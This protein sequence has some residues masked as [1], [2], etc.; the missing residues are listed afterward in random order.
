MSVFEETNVRVYF[1]EL[2]GGTILEFCRG[3]LE[4]TNNRQ[5]QVEVKRGV[6][7]CPCPQTLGGLMLT[8][9]N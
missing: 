7:S 1:S 8:S 4:S 6:V 9:F 2:D 5:R 3:A